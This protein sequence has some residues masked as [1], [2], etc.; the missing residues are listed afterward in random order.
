MLSNAMQRRSTRRASTVVLAVGA[1]LA[2]GAASAS[3]ATVGGTDSAPIFNAVAGETNNVTVTQDVN[4]GQ[5]TFHDAGQAITSAGGCTL[6]APNAGDVTCAPAGAVTSI[7]LNLDDNNDTT[8]FTAVTAAIVQNGGLG[9]DTLAASDD[10]ASSTINGDDGIDA[11]NGGA[12]IDTING[13]AGNDVIAGGGGNDVINGGADDDTIVNDAGSDDIH[14][15]AGADTM[16]YTGPGP[17]PA[18]VNVTLDDIA[19]DGIAGENDNVHSDVDAVLSDNAVGGSDTMHGGAGADFFE[20]FL[21]DDSIDLIDGAAD[22]GAVCDEGNDIVYADAADL[23][24][25]GFDPGHTCEAV[26]DKDAMSFGSRTTGQS[27]AAQTV[28]V[29]NHS[30]A[31]IT[32]GTVASSGQFNKSADTCS[33]ATLA[34][35][36]TCTVS[37]SFAPTS[38]GAL[39]GTLTIPTAG[40]PFSIALSGTGVAPVVVTPPPAVTVTPPPPPPPP[41]PAVVSKPAAA[42][43]VSAKVKPA[44]DRSKPYAFT[45]SGKVALPTGVSNANGCKGTVTITLKKGKKTI[46]SKKATV[47]KDCTYSAKVK[48]KSKAKMTAAAKFGGNA[49]VGAKT[50]AKINV[51]AG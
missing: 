9:D 21:G 18:D 51:R 5:V 10:S 31:P 23:T 42:K 14:G 30:G 26:A 27:A 29:R 38:V 32:L 41:P 8:S 12:G 46:T 4:T 2:G 19:N 33:G 15:G 22:F 3:A 47:R 6:D 35:D 39:A 16:I 13:G 11:I 45:F 24:A 48:V 49:A 50:S 28:T 7:T 1:L 25:M 44:R 17:G 34:A 37:A 43:S 20:S 36:A 40:R